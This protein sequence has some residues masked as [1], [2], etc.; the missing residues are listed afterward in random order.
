MTIADN[1]SFIEHEPS[2]DGM[3]MYL[4]ASDLAAVMAEDSV[5]DSPSP[6][7]GSSDQWKEVH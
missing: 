1:K 5:M 2:M 3:S 7:P 4:C 6:G